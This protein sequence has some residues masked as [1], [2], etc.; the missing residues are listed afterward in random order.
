MI[1]LIP[2]FM[3]IIVVAGLVT[4]LINTYNRLIILSS[5]SQKAFT[6]LD[7]ILK[8]HADEILHLI[9]IVK[10]TVLYEN[11]TLKELASLHTQYLNTREGYEKMKTAESMDRKLRSLI[12]TVESHPAIKSNRSYL[13]LQKRLADLE[14]IIAGRKTYFNESVNLYNTAIE[15]FPD[16]IFAKMMNYRKK[17]SL[18]FSNIEIKNNPTAL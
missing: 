5:N 15:T 18:R 9:T 14:G 3:I 4:F 10:A 6:S 13:E 2:L 11:T 12:T 16:L 8:Q 1:S 17:E 7:M